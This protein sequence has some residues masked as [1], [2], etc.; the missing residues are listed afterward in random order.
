MVVENGKVYSFGEGCAGQL[1]HGDKESTILTPTPIKAPLEGKIIVQIACGAVHSLALSS[2]GV[3]F[4]WGCGGCGQL[5]HGS[6]EEYSFPSNVESLLGYMVVKIVHSLDYHSVALVESNKQS[7]EK[8]MKL[9]INDEACSD[10]EFILKDDERV[11]ANKGLLIGQ[12]EYF[13]AMFRSNMK[14]SRENVI[15]VRDCPK[16]VFLLFLEYLYTGS[17]DI[18]DPEKVL[19]TLSH[20]YQEDDL[21]KCCLK[22]VWGEL[23]DESAMTLLIKAN[24]MVCSSGTALK[25]ICM[26]Y[27]ISHYETSFQAEVVDSLPPS[28]MAELLCRLHFRCKKK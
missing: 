20:R 7:Y 24:S 14:E 23:S 15:E 1:G 11:H 25:D 4:A 12:S 8:K 10:V 21:S 27:V 18:V 13:R 5:G 22:V 9:M 28:L 6:R 3:L 26:E 19:Y 17:L 16:D 2:E